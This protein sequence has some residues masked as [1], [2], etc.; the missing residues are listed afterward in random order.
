MEDLEKKAELAKLIESASHHARCLIVA[1]QSFNTCVNDIPSW[2]G[3]ERSPSE[4]AAYIY[5]ED[6]KILVKLMENS[7]YQIRK[8]SDENS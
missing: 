3:V 4:T 7:F 2:D 6:T 5:L 1:A 8:F